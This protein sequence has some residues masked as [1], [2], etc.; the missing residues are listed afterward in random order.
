[1]TLEVFPQV[2]DPVPSLIAAASYIKNV[3]SAIGT[4]EG[5]QMKKLAKGKTAQFDPKKDKKLTIF[6]AQ[7]WPSWQTKYIELVRSQLENL[8]V[9]DVKEASKNIE[10]ADMKKAMPFLQTLKRK[11]DQGESRENIF[12]RKLP[13]DEISVLKE[14][15]PGLKSS[16]P[17][18]VDASIIL[19]NE[20]GKTGKDAL[21]GAKLEGLPPTAASAEPGSPSF[22]FANV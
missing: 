4:A 20:D 16:V 3:T 7:S 11:L 13:F 8:G 6:V 9:V 1:V 5:T 14:M 21:S 22:D 19:V 17:K 2:P 10:K 18:L 12:E 15:A